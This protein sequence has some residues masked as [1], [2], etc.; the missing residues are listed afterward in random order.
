MTQ[1]VNMSDLQAHTL[2]GE[3]NWRHS[4]VFGQSRPKQAVSERSMTL[5]QDKRP[6]AN[7]LVG[8]S[9]YPLQ[10][11]IPVN[12]YVGRVSVGCCISF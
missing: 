11:H 6:E 12:I 10:R 4:L 9:Q 1:S 7:Q 8:V 3:N 5:A 2:S